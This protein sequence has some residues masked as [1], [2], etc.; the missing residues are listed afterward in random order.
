MGRPVLGD[1]PMSRKEIEARY[2]S[3]QAAEIDE[4]RRALVALIE[5]LP[6]GCPASYMAKYGGVVA[7]AYEAQKKGE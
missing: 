5:V 1:A 6:R 2:R 3:K 4:L 7:R